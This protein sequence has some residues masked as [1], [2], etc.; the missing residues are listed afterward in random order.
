MFHCNAQF[1]PILLLRITKVV[2]K[3][4]GCSEQSGAIFFSYYPVNWLVTSNLNKNEQLLS[5]RLLAHVNTIS[6]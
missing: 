3:L 4:R 6:W 2:I 1:E 5:C